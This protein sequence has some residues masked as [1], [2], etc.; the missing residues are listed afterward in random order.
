MPSCTGSWQRMRS[1]QCDDAQLLLSE[2]TWGSQRPMR[3]A[4]PCPPDCWPEAVRPRG[5]PA[6]PGHKLSS[7][8]SETHCPPSWPCGWDPLTSASHPR[9]RGLMQGRHWT[10]PTGAPGPTGQHWFLGGGSAPASLSLS[11]TGPRWLG[12]GGVRTQRDRRCSLVLIPGLGHTGPG[13]DPCPV[14][15]SSHVP[16]SHLP[17][18]S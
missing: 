17:C 18:C 8:P 10:W 11:Y 5:R 14:L 12:M 7:S 16:T 15:R 4:P 2:A 3:T 13:A 9:G 6:H 1:T